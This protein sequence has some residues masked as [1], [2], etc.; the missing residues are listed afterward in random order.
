LSTTGAAY[1]PEITPSV[2]LFNEYFGGGMNSVVFQEIRE[3]QGLAYSAASGYAQASSKEKSDVLWAYL[4]VQADKQPEAMAAMHALLDELPKSEIG[5]EVSKDAIL[6][7][8]E[9]E[10]ITRADVIWSYL[11]AEKK[12]VDYDLRKDIYNRVKE[13][14]FD[15]LKAFHAEHIKGQP[16]NT[17]LVGNKD[18][19]NFKD[20]EQYG[21]VQ[22]LSL[23]EIFGYGDTE[24]IDMR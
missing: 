12:G 16:L 18:F 8:L 20:L 9:S 3:A 24:T 6:N 21:E 7:Q 11:D 19:I 22:E 5:F 4:G 14:T 13:M 15:D 1:R 23:D 17:V 10:R 2:A